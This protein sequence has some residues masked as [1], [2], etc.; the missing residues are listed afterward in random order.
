MAK[1]RHWSEAECAVLVALYLSS[2]F[3]IADDGRSENSLISADLGRNPSSIDR[4]WRNI[5]DYLNRLE[6]KNISQTLKY[7]CDAAVEDRDTLIRLALFYC[8][9]FDWENIGKFI[10]DQFKNRE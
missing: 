7:F 5:K 8:D 1:T 9:L 6:G 10:N 3:S 2:K 4:Q